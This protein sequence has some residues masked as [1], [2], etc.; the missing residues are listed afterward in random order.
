MLS[1]MEELYEAV[2]PEHDVQWLD[3]GSQDVLDRVR[4][5][6]GNPQADLW[7]GGPMMMF[8]RAEREG[9]LDS[10]TPGWDSSVAPEAKSA[11]GRWYGTAL[12]PEVIMYN[13]RTVDSASAPHDWDDLLSARWKDRIIIRLPMASGT[14]R[15]MFTAIMEREFRRT[16]TVEA[17]LRWLRA[18]D[19]NTRAYAADPTQ[20]Y[21][22]IAREE[23]DVSI[24]DLP[25]VVIQ[26]REH[27]YPFGYIVPATGTP[28]I[29]DGIGLIKGA[30]HRAAAISFYEYVTSQECAILQAARFFRIP[31]RNDIPTSSLPD[32]ISGLRVTPMDVDWRALSLKEQEWMRLWDEQVKGRGKEAG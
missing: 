27:G 7:W 1:V 4:T 25:D 8:D 15:M 21:L 17:G 30:R 10:Y 29:T 19:A 16:G 22:K 11:T 32:W 2:H 5:E 12:L 13:S 28:V 14:M 20:L 9:L 26:A 18:L 6:K 23:G 3:M 24:W 31:A